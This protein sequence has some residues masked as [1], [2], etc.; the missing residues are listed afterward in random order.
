MEDKIKELIKKY[1]ESSYA[2]DRFSSPILDAV[3]YYDG[4]ES[5]YDEVIE[6]LEKLL[7]DS[8]K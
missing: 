1:T 3:T 2:C 6:D 8:L 5:V 4:K 7:K